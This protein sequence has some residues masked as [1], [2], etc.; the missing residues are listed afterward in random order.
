[1]LATQIST[2]G[3]VL[4][5]MRQYKELLTRN[6]ELEWQAEDAKKEALTR[7]N[8]SVSF[9]KPED[10]SSRLHVELSEADPGSTGE[11]WALGSQESIF[12]LVRM[13][14]LFATAPPPFQTGMGQCIQLKGQTY[15][16]G[17]RL[18]AV[19]ENSIEGIDPAVIDET[20]SWAFDGI[21]VEVENN[22]ALRDRIILGLH[23]MEKIYDYQNGDY[24][25]LEEEEKPAL[26]AFDKIKIAEPLLDHVAYT[27]SDSTQLR[28]GV[29]PNTTLD[30]HNAIMN[31]MQKEAVNMVLTSGLIVCAAET[32][33]AKNVAAQRFFDLYASENGEEAA[34]DKVLI[35]DTDGIEE[36]TKNSGQDLGPILP[37]LMLS[38]HIRRAAERN[39]AVYRDWL[40]AE[41][42]KAQFGRI[43]DPQ[44]IRKAA[45]LKENLI[46][47]VKMQ[48]PVMFS[49]L[50]CI[51]LKD[52]F[53]GNP[54]DPLPAF[55]CAVFLTDETSQVTVPRWVQ[56]W[57]TL[58]P[59]IAS[60]FGDHKQ[61]RPYV[62][63]ELAEKVMGYSMFE[64][65][66]N[67]K[68]PTRMLKVEY[69]TLEEISCGTNVHYDK[70]VQ[71]PP[72]L[73]NHQQPE[74][75]EFMA[76]IKRI[77][78]HTDAQAEGERTQLNHN[79]F[80][81]N[82]QNSTCF[83]VGES[84]SSVNHAEA[85]VVQGLFGCLLMCGIP[86]QRL[87]GLNAYNGQ[88]DELRRRLRRWGVD[89]RKVAGFQGGEKEY[90]C[91]SAV[92]TPT[93][94]IGF[95]KWPNL[96]NV[97]TSRSMFAFI[98]VATLQTFIDAEKYHPEW[99]STI[100][101]LANNLLNKSKFFIDVN[102]S[103]TQWY[104]DDMPVDFGNVP[105]PENVVSVVEETRLPMAPKPSQEST[106]ATTSIGAA[107]SS[108]VGL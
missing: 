83:A 10:G 9:I 41:R 24:E 76:A 82:I 22:E 54:G 104:I 90:V 3:N 28:L 40:R 77:S 85:N 27:P 36:F 37:K 20:C 43:K 87:L 7:E 106:S 80:M 19:I 105:P 46:R 49:T 100:N 99:M 84:R 34:I 48:E 47:D 42:E 60:F 71:V 78:F 67:K 73:K 72:K 21:K 57:V 64:K 31:A 6:L 4:S 53:F 95:L 92:R 89:T 14:S 15:V 65:H 79:V 45:K 62:E 12:F 52:V 51:H 93:A 70:K 86:A 2:Q 5:P 18:F 75:L 44:L 17:G 103:V 108:G 58:N 13:H 102:G 1:M 33:T 101:A 81:L 38:A 16:K 56:A 98:L 29:T 26:K 107:A 91:F 96:Q 30:L 23:W 69:R 50:A 39:P 68:A 8:I 94:K 25:P 66:I 63:N 88:N 11:A 32:N 74:Y 55:R 35:I 61:L 59:T 97:A